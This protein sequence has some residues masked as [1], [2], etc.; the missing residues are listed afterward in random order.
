M[1]DNQEK[2]MKEVESQRDLRKFA[3]FLAVIFA[4]ILIL[5]MITEPL[6]S[7]IPDILGVGD[8][9][10][11]S[12]DRVLPETS[13]TGSYTNSETQELLPLLNQGDSPELKD[14]IQYEVQQ[15]E[16]IYQIAVQFGVS[17]EDIA[18][19]NRLVSLDRVEEGDVL[20]IPIME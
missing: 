12:S 16:T 18:S 6:G 2:Q 17:V 13:E 5:A 9:S 7:R 1:N 14:A 3:V 10:D 20:I 8:G 11:T 15:G 19:M 4:L